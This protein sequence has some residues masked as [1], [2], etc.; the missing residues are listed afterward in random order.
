MS[1]TIIL[2]RVQINIYAKVSRMQYAGWGVG[3]GGGSRAKFHYWRNIEID[4]E[5]R[6][7]DTWRSRGARST[8]SFILTAIATSLFKTGKIGRSLVG[9]KRRG[10]WGGRLV[11]RTQRT[12]IQKSVF[13]PNHTQRYLPKINVSSPKE[14]KANTKVSIDIR[15]IRFRY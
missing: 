1:K 14:Q 8:L 10:G 15:N 13:N 2:H 4:P 11:G 12:C 5:V 9:N 7:A 3:W 6:R